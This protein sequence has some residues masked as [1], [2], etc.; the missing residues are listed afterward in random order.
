VRINE[1][2]TN[3]DKW[4]GIRIPIVLSAVSSCFAAYSDD[5]VHDSSRLNIVISIYIV[6][7]SL[8]ISI[9]FPCNFDFH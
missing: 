2:S 6:I 8:V 9:I 3:V 5:Y 4:S 1:V 7:I